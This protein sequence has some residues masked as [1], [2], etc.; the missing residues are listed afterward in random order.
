[1]YEWFID[2]LFSYFNFRRTQQLF[3]FMVVV[4]FYWWRRKPR[5]FTCNNRF[6]NSRSTCT[7]I[8]TLNLISFCRWRAAESGPMLTNYGQLERRD[9]YQ[10]MSAVTLRFGFFLSH[11]IYF[12]KLPWY[13]QTLCYHILTILDWLKLFFTPCF[14]YSA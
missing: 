2:W 12:L 13:I 14:L 11:E 10:A 8:S 7:C 3:S 4:S 1:V 6:N 9:L 5:Y